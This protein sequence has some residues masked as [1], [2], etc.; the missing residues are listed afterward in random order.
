MALTVSTNS[1]INVFNGIVGKD[2]NITGVATDEKGNLLT[3]IILNVT[4]NGVSYTVTTNSIGGWFL[5]YTPTKI[6]IFEVEV[7]Y[8]GNGTY[9]GL[10]I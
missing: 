3:N 4:V 6:G 7:S 10:L 8:I 1:T 2:M 9:Y 5:T